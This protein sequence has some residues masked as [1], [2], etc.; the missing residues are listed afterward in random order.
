MKQPPSVPQ[1]GTESESIEMAQALRE[2]YPDPKSRPENVRRM[3]EKADKH[4][5]KHLTSAL[6]KTTDALDK[7]RS[8][9]R[10]LQQAQVKH[11]NSWLNHLKTVM[12]GLEKQMKSFDE[13]Q[14]DYTKRVAHARRD[15]AVSRREIQRLNT[16]AATASLPETIIDEEEAE[17]TLE[18]DQEERDLRAQVNEVL[19]KC[20]QALKPKDRIDLT[21][22]DD[23]ME[24]G[25]SNK[26]A[27]SSER[28]DGTSFGLGAK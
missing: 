28:Q 3:L 26:R 6:H 13:Q 18:I 1:T 5:S 17:T 19:T 14:E 22:D 21:S 2:A 16:Q 11:R 4:T 15:I 12:E 27:R 25:I 10:G 20:V 7:A 8:T 23:V 9:L 24:T